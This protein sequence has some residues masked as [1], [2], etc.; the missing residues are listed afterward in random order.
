ML[1]FSTLLLLAAALSSAAELQGVIADWNCVK[2][3]VQ[4][5]REKTL[6]QNRSCSLM[7]N[8]SR[9]DYG[10]ITDDEH[11]YKLDDAGRKWA[12]RLLK[13]TIDK[14]NLKVVVTGEIKGDTIHVTNMSEL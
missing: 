11:F 13:D 7:G 8:Y 6:K 2:P 4:N 14:D 1:R 10:V 12:L 5:G 9:A 3:I